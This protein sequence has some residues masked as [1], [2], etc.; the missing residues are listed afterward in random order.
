MAGGEGGNIDT[1]KASAV[2]GRVAKDKVI[3]IV[4]EKGVPFFGNLRRRNS[5]E[6]KKR[7][8]K[9]RDDYR[10]KDG[11]LRIWEGTSLHL[12]HKMMGKNKTIEDRS[13]V[14]RIA[15]GKRWCTSW[16]NEEI[17][18]ACEEAPRSI[19]HTLINVGMKG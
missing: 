8:L 18:K 2:M 17:C 9:K 5:K 12:S 19:R 11:K 1:I 14:A 3:S 15:F 4:D 10:E 16:I 6:K 13:A 7:Y